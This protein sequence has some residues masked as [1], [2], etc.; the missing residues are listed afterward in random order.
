LISSLDEPVDPPDKKE[1]DDYIEEN[2]PN[3]VKTDVNEDLV[4]RKVSFNFRS[5]QNEVI[6]TVNPIEVINETQIQTE[7]LQQDPVN[8]INETEHENLQK[9]ALDSMGNLK[10]PVFYELKIDLKNGKNMAIRD[11]NGNKKFHSTIRLFN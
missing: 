10:V 3:A 6:A 2:E 11:R 7:L 4:K 1:V 5:P 8:K 9:E